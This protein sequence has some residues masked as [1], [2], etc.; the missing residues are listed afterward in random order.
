M[1]LRILVYPVLLTLAFI[2]TSCHEKTANVHSNG[3]SVIATLFPVYDFAREITGGKAQVTLLL[4]PGVEAHSFEPRPAD[5]L[6]MNKADLFIYT[7]NEMEPW[8]DKA[9]HAIDNKNLI[10]IDAGKGVKPLKDTKRH[11]ESGTDR[12]VHHSGNDPHILLDF[13]NAQ[14]MVDHITDGL[15]AGNREEYFGFTNNAAIFKQKLHELDK[16]YEIALSHCSKQTFVHAGHFAFS[17]LAARYNL[18]YVSAYGS[19]PNAEPTPQKIIELKKIIRDHGIKYIFYEELMAPRMAEVISRETGVQLLKL[20]G[21]HNITRDEV[22]RG[23]T[24]IDLMEEN[25][26]NLKVGLECR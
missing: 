18:H 14:Q 9:L 20:N 23:V 21:A 17:Y 25:L 2:L 3:L 24:F 11:A 22:A 26:T 6:A 1:K 19:S 13:S 7:G 8:V 12:H 4:P 10:V 15:N 5:V 16:K